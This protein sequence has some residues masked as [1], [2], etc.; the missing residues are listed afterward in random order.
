MAAR[1]TAALLADCDLER[2]GIDLFGRDSLLLG[3][4]LTCLVRSACFLRCAPLQSATLHLHA[5]MQ[6]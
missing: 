5:C 2:Q 3:R 1:W 6:R 4:L